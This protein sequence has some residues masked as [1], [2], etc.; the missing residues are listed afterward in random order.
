MHPT[1]DLACNPG[2]C[3]DWESNPQPFDSQAHAQSSELHQPGRNTL[4]LFHL[5]IREKI[6]FYY[7]VSMY[8]F[9]YIVQ[10]E[11]SPFSCHNFPLPYPP[12]LPL[13]ILFPFWLCPWDLNIHSST[14][15]PLLSSVIPLAPPLWL[16]SVCS[17]FQCLWLY[18]TCLFVLLIRFHL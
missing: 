1:G 5:Y 10:E 4:F 3:S 12:H 2:M 14:T 16:L 15:L 6:I 11:L 17:L 8:V 18:Y 13:S 9:I 7:F